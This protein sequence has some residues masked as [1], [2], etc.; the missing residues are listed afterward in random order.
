MA[1]VLV[2]AAPAGAKPRLTGGGKFSQPVQVAAPPGD[3]RLFVVE[4]AGR[5]R[6]LG[7]DGTLAARPFLDVSKRGRARRGAGAARPRL[8]ARL[9]DDRRVLR[10]PD[11][12]GARGPDP[13][14]PVPRLG[15]RSQPR[16]PGQRRRPSCARTR[17]SS[18]RTTAA[19]CASGPT[20]S[21]GSRSATAGGRNDNLRSG[22]SLKTLLGKVAAHRARRRARR[23]QP[24]RRRDGRHAAGDLAVRA[25][26]P[27]PLLLRPRERG[28]GARRRRRGGPRG[29]RPRARRAGPAARRE[30]GLAVL[31]GLDGG[32][33]VRG[34]GRDRARLRAQPRRGRRARGRGRR[35]RPRPRP[36]DARR[37]LPVRRPRLTTACTRWRSPRSRTGR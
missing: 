7:E 28:P 24:V 32:Q 12:D 27:L 6:V 13:G 25:A 9:R 21:C 2:C 14:P 36:A 34:A 35:R 20:A 17:A 3:E 8:R 22:Q 18:R 15:R 11:G 4:L 16:R 23:R 37:A 5:I 31:R 19:V 26:Q 29:D 30:L 33:R 1:A 10:P